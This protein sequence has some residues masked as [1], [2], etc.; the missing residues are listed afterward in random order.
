MPL[1]DPENVRVPVPL[2]RHKSPMVIAVDAVLKTVSVRAADMDAD[3]KIMV[4]VPTD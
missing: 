3:E 2:I 4:R 1:P